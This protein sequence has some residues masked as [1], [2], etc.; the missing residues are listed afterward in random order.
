VKIQYRITVDGEPFTHYQD[1][2]ALD[3]VVTLRRRYP[4]MDIGLQSRQVTEWVKCSVPNTDTQEND[5]AV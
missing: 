5:D 4:K 3:R 2:F 1:E